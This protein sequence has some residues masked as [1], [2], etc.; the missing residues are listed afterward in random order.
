MTMRSRLFRSG[1]VYS[2]ANRRS[3]IAKI[4]YRKALKVQVKLELL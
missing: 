1:T 3:R 4:S 2:N